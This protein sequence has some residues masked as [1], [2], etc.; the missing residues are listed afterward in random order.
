MKNENKTT[1]VLIL[2]FPGK[3]T[4]W[5][6][7]KSLKSHSANF[8]VPWRKFNYIWWP[9]FT[10][11]S[12]KKEICRILEYEILH[13]KT[14]F[15]RLLHTVIAHQNLLIMN[16]RAFCLRMTIAISRYF[17][18]LKGLKTVW[19]SRSFE[20]FWLLDMRKKPTKQVPLRIKK[21]K[22][23][24]NKITWYL[25]VKFKTRGKLATLQEARKK[26]GS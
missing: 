12:Y 7:R 6:Q 26:K 1:R 19:Q 13:R 24:G 10:E 5:N 14:D 8:F 11:K 22:I 17:H 25:C 23:S 21:W 20:L 3:N 4:F 9:R 18:A 2:I 15:F 16:K